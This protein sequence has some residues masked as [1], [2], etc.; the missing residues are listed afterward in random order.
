[1]GNVQ[2]EFRMPYFQNAKKIKT[3]ELWK[4]MN[5]TII[6]IVQMAWLGLAFPYEFPVSNWL[7]NTMGTLDLLWVSGIHIMLISMRQD[8]QRIA[9]MQRR[10]G[11]QICFFGWQYLRSIGIWS[12]VS[13]KKVEWEL[14]FYC[15]ASLLL[16]VSI[17][18]LHTWLWF[19]WKYLI[20]SLVLSCLVCLKNVLLSQ[21]IYY[22]SASEMQP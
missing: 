7:D 21:P 10:I 3:F 20:S 13:R 17:K 4:E 14:D 8:A 5:I 1:M 12:L 6:R 11:Y 15:F 18:F 16:S 2:N 19:I 22:E 9:R